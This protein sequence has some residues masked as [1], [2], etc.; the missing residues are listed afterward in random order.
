MEEKIS[1]E[2]MNKFISVLKS[3]GDAGGMES[4]SA[5]MNVLLK[6]GEIVSLWSAK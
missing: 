2:E 6:F 3:I 1:E 5:A 4:K